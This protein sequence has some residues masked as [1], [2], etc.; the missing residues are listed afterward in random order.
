MPTFTHLQVHSHFSLLGGTAAP[1]ELVRR[2]ATDGFS[3]LA[4]TDSNALYGAVI[5][6]K[7]CRAAGIEPI[8][9]MTVHVVPPPE[10]SGFGQA[11]GPGQLVLL[12]MGPAGYR[13]LCR[14]SAVLQ[15]RPERESVLAQGL[16][17]E[18]LAACAEGL[19]CLSGG[20]GHAG[21]WVER[22]LR[23]GQADEAG[24]YMARLR[25]LYGERACLSVEL[26]CP[27]DEAI[28]A[29]VVA[30][31]Q[32]FGLPVVAVQPVYCLEPADAPRLQLLAAMDHNCTLD[33]V[34]PTALPAAGDPEATLHWLS[35][36]EIQQRFAA[37]PQ[38]VTAVSDVLARCQP[39]LPDGRPVWPAIRPA[40]L[41]PAVTAESA[42][43]EQAQAGLQHR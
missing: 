2:A 8:I 36:D 43:N 14:L 27:Q 12:A 20:P 32:R 28:A 17:W 3:H 24:R 25:Q 11:T 26:H 41:A 5:F 29:E 37:F 10:A 31:G 42:L 33:A 39:A 35:L 4:L 7:A 22:Y 30:M 6:A 38:A 15:G 40:N 21:G 34:P 1:A 23:V 9:G 19:L 13:S 16:D 18:T